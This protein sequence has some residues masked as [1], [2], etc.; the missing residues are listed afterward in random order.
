MYS[1]TVRALYLAHVYFNRQAAHTIVKDFGL[2]KALEQVRNTTFS[3]LVVLKMKY[4][5]YCLPELNIWHAQL[6]EVR[7]CV[8]ASGPF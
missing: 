2:I 3:H 1:F 4:L 5:L 6:V 7:R 8:E